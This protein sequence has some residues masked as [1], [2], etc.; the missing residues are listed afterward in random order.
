MKK[1]VIRAP[2]LSISGYGEHSRQVFKYLSTKTDIMLKANIVQWGNTAWHINANEC[3]GL[4]GKIMSVSV[5]D[6]SGYDVSFQV[7]LPDEWSN[8][9]ATFNVGITAGVETDICDKKWIDGINRMNLVIVPSKFVKDTFLR[10]GE[11]TTPI[12]VV[13][14]WYQENLDLDPLQSI[15][16]LKFDT[17]FNFLV[18][19]QLT[20]T[21]ENSDRKNIINTIKWICE[22]FENDKDVGIVLKTNLGRGTFIDREAV[23]NLIKNTIRSFRKGAFPRIHVIHGN[24]TDR[25]MT[26][27]YTHPSVKALINLTRGE[28]FGL[29]ILDAAVAGLPVIT[30]NATGH[31]DFMKLGKFVGVEYD[32]VE[33]PK[34]RVDNRIFIEGAKWVNPRESDFKKRVLKFR[35]SYMTPK[36]WARDLSTKCKENFSRQKIESDYDTHLRDILS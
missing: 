11:V 34:D 5:G 28:G 33:I 18:V 15:H 26:S 22:S 6:D 10:S 25:E 13:G 4:V 3:D 12:V 27:L 9:L 32:A 7:Q 36:E 8:T 29:P 35:S 19:S 23:L 14:V 31:L 20:S 21:N 16:D 30:T 17:N 2:L 24:M 1:V